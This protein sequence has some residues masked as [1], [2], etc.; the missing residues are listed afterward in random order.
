MDARPYETLWSLEDPTDRVRR[1][2]DAYSWLGLGRGPYAWDDYRYDENVQDLIRDLQ[3]AI[4]DSMGGTLERARLADEW[5]KRTAG[6][7]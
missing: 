7:T 2:V 5:K 6:G 4:D 3:L 1:I